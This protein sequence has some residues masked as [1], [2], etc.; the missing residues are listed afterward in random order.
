MNKELREVFSDISKLN[1]VLEKIYNE[2]AELEIN[3]KTKDKEYLDNLLLID[4][5]KD[6]IRK[7]FQNLSITTTEIIDFESNIANLNDLNNSNFILDIF[8]LKENNKI[9]RLLMQIYLYSLKNYIVEINKTNYGL[10]E[11]DFDTT[12]DFEEFNNNIN[13]DITENVRKEYDFEYAKE[14][15]IANLLMKYLLEEINTQED[16]YIKDTLIKIKYR[17]IYTLSTLEPQFLKDPNNFVKENLYL[18]LYNYEVENV[19]DDI[20]DLAIIPDLKTAK[21]EI[22]YFENIEDEFYENKD[23]IIKIILRSIYLKT[24]ISLQLS[25]KSDRTLN[26][27][28]RNIKYKSEKTKEYINKAYTLKKDIIKPKKVDL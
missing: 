14:K 16:K 26:R 8:E 1:N 2:L 5:I 15:V 18:E 19:I 7:K 11:E 9:R 23:N 25:S 20:E 4:A 27:K 13:E 10:S 3:N 28:K 24:M 21:E 17:L 12:E 6:L 22:E